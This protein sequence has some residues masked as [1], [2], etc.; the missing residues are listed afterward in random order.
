MKRIILLIFL[1][2]CFQMGNFKRL[3]ISVDK[4]PDTEKYASNR[5]QV[6][7]QDLRDQHNS[8]LLSL[9]RR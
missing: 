7:R 8:G 1:Y 4:T 6:D 5:V 9:S 3:K 2:H